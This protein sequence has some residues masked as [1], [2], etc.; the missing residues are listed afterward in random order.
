MNII[1]AVTAA[2]IAALS[3]PAALHFTEV[4]ASD[5]PSYKAYLKTDVNSD[6]EVNAVDASLVLEEYVE[7]STGQA[8]E[9]T[10]T[11]K[12]VSD[13]D[14]D[15]T[16]S[17]VD[18]SGI[19]STYACNSTS[20]TERSYGMVTFYVEYWTAGV[21]SGPVYANSY[22]ECLSIIAEE[23]KKNPQPE[24]SAY[25]IVYSEIIFGENSDW[26]IKVIHRE[27]GGI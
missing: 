16:I 18:A 12:Y 13:Y 6:G 26:I 17:S 5:T 10:G 23:K 3:L 24:N 2:V 19:L 14:N 9:L 22:E 11:M 4:A 25:D 8:G 1:K 7:V 20:N 27:Q 21:K 15:G